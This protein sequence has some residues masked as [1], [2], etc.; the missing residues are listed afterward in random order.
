MMA[1]RL[2]ISETT[3]SKY[4][5]RWGAPLEQKEGWELRVNVDEIRR[6]V[7]LSAQFPGL[8][9]PIARITLTYEQARVLYEDLDAIVD[10]LVTEGAE[11]L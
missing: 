7:H 9:H 6:V 11:G 10:Q 2:G 4:Y 8:G 3:A 5:A 1:A